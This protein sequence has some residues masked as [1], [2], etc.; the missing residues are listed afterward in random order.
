M[1]MVGKVSI[2]D[3]VSEQAREISL[4]EGVNY[5]PRVLLTKS[6]VTSLKCKKKKKLVKCS[7]KKK[8]LK[9]KSNAFKSRRKLKR[10]VKVV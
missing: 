5:V 6:K 7:T 9:K 10:S 3:V 8:L 1:G 2:N 4:E